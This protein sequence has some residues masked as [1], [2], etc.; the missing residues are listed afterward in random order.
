[1]VLARVG[2]IR[3]PGL[4]VFQG[5]QS[6]GVITDPGGDPPDPPGV[7]THGSQ[8][9]RYNVGRPDGFYGGADTRSVLSAPTVIN[10]RSYTTA[11]SNSTVTNVRFTSNVVCNADNITFKFCIFD[12]PVSDAGGKYLFTNDTGRV[13]F[14]DCTFV[15]RYGHG[16]TLYQRSRG[17]M[18]L[19][20]CLVLGSED[21]YHAGRGSGGNPQPWPNEACA[22][23]TGARLIIEDSFLG[24]GV[25]YADGHIDV[26]QFDTSE[27]LRVGNMIVRRSK[28][29]A[30]SIN[31][32]SG[33]RSAQGSPTNPA[34]GAVMLTHGTT[35]GVLGYFS[36][37]KC[38]LDGGNVT[39][40]ANPPDGPAAQIMAVRDC[41]FG[42]DGTFTHGGNTCMGGSRY[43]T[44]IAG[45]GAYRSNN[46]W[47]ATGTYAKFGGGTNPNPTYHSVTQGAPVN[48]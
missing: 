4:A 42:A 48:L 26:I 15:G 17:G 44:G 3:P 12:G 30:Y 31:S 5:W 27:G 39:I 13:Y 23:F 43:G 28:L 45:D 32:P 38:Q 22:D 11:D 8:V 18:W 33:P 16:K 2:I 10:G 24:D 40:N 14:D 29:L 46:T 47:A 41:T 19:K 1:M 37:E 7:F 20:R 21:I 25:R 34:N 6:P 9:F 36:L 35:S